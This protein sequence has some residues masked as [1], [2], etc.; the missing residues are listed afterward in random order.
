MAFIVAGCLAWHFLNSVS[1]ILCWA[2]ANYLAWET[3][4]WF[5]DLKIQAWKIDF[6]QWKH[7]CYRKVGVWVSFQHKVRMWPSY[8]PSWQLQHS[9]SAQRWLFSLF[10]VC[11]TQRR[12]QEGKCNIISY[13]LQGEG[14]SLV[15]RGS[16]ER[17]KGT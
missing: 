10:F 13:T 14:Q 1:L 12:A 5:S 8:V 3:Q 2:K 9:L 7:G 6:S 17:K 15:L 4:T 11:L 16:G